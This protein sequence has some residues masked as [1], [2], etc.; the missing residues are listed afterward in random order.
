MLNVSFFL[1]WLLIMTQL[2]SRTQE[3]A[4]KIVGYVH[5]IWNEYSEKENKDDRMRHLQLISV[6]FMN[7]KLCF[8]AG[9][10]FC[11]DATFTHMVIGAVLTYVVILI[12]FDF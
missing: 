1:L 2:Y 10:L 9:K 5:E 12:Q 6:A 11:L 7:N 3:E 4:N 8:T